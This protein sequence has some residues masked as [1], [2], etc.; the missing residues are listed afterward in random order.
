MRYYI[1]D[2][3]FFHEALNTQ[4][5]NRGF[6][7]VE[8]MNT[9]MISQWNKKI[10]KKDEVFILGDF[11]YAKGEKTNEILRQLNGKLYLIQGNHDYFVKD[12]KFDSSRFEWILPYAEIHDN[13]RKVILSHYPVFCYNGQYR[14]LKSGEPRTYMLYGHVHDTQD[15]QLVL[16][17]QQIT[18]NTLH[19][20]RYIPC[21]M[22]NCFCM[23]SD[24]QPLSLDE[25]IEFHRKREEGELVTEGKI[26]ESKE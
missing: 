5:D 23:Y 21:N 15:Q 7:T 25:W 13:G 24:Y 11:S 12:K 8:E 19:N 6:A 17:F 18:R 9:Y 26:S 22:L 16:Q 4:M 1:S 3:H 14:L 10:K 2:M 20:E